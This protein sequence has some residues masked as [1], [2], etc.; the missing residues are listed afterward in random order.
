MTRARDVVVAGLGLV[1]LSP[2]LLIIAV[3]V[4]LDSP[5]PALYRQVRVGLHGTPFRIH[6]FRSMATGGV[7]P[8]VTASDD[9][10]ITRV[11]RWLR[12]SKLDELPQLIDV[13]R[14]KMSLVGPRPEDPRYVDHWPSDLRPEILSVRPGITDPATVL[15]RNEAEILAQSPDPER[16]YVEELLPLKAQAYLSYV[17]NRSFVGDIS[18][19]LATLQA[20]ILPTPNARLPK[21][22]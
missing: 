8:A 4:R 6:K 10:R 13:L 17:R 7:G 5:G 3:L 20:I 1:L 22:L 9:P 21:D 15:L 18:V 14:G 16:T 19:I 11:G 12:A 2:L